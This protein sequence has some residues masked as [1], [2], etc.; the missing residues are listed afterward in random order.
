MSNSDTVIVWA[1]LRVKDGLADD[2]I[3]ASQSVK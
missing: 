2:F 1:G 3:K